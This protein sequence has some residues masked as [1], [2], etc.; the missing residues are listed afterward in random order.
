M[1]IIAKNNDGT[2]KTF[3]LH[4]KHMVVTKSYKYSQFMVT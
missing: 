3:L 1:H 2:L 4:R